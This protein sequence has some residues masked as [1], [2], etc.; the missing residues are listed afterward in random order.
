MIKYKKLQVRINGKNLEAAC[1]DTHFAILKSAP[2][3]D[4]PGTISFRREHGSFKGVSLTAEV[5]HRVVNNDG[6]NGHDLTLLFPQQRD[7]Y[8]KFAQDFFEV[9]RRLAFEATWESSLDDGPD[10]K[11]ATATMSMAVET[12]PLEGQ[13]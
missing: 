8:D 11:F 3:P 13:W 5:I 9:V 7:T 12:N 2:S 10:M 1:K 4:W 6:I